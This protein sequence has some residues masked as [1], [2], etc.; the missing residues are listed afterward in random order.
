M[1]SFKELAYTVMGLASPKCGVDAAVLRL[2]SSSLGSLNFS[3]FNC[4]NRGRLLYLKSNDD[5]N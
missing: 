1:I 4:F 3:T 5:R 2:I